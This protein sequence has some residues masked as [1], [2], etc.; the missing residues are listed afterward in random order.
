MPAALASRAVDAIAI[1]EPHA[2]NALEAVGADSVTFQNGSAYAERFNL[3]TTTTVLADPA[4]RRALVALIRLL[5]RAAEDTRKHP[6]EARRLASPL[7]SIP[8]R[9]IAA[10]W[11][12]FKFPADLRP[13]VA[14]VLDE[15]E[16]WAAASQNRPRRSR[17]QLAILLDRTLL[18]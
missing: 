11:Q 17:A 15:V 7:L 14:T 10:T 1:W 6:A 2:Q 18:P 12:H 4:K 8:E 3:N 9:T 5:E 16:P 13:E